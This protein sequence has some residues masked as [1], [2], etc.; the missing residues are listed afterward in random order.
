MLVSFAPPG[1][2]PLISIWSTFFLFL[3][4]VVTAFTSLAAFSQGAYGASSSVLRF[5]YA[6]AQSTGMRTP[7]AWALLAMRTMPAKGVQTIR[8]TPK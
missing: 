5:S 1:F 4:R 7:R 8:P 6:V 3:S 2:L